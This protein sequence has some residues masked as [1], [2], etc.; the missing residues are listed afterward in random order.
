MKY[1]QF[2]YNIM[3]ET[4]FFVIINEYNVMVNSDELISISEY[5]M[6]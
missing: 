3:K 2:G 1:N 4:K 5:L 6:L